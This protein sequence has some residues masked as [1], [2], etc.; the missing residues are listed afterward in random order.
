MDIKENISFKELTTFKVGGFAKRVVYPKSKEEVQ[1][2]FK[3]LKESKEEFIVLGGGSN[4]VASDEDFSGTVIVPLIETINFTK[5]CV[6]VGS[7]LYWDKFVQMAV[8]NRFWGV[9]NLSAIPGTVG[10]AVPPFKI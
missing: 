10:G 6:V 4:V 7:G 3:E 9:E 1:R 8:E 2:L 5:E